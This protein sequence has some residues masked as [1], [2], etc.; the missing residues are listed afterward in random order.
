MIERSAF[1]WYPPML[2]PA[3]D[4]YQASL[5]SR[6][7]GDTVSYAYFQDEDPN[8]FANITDRVDSIKATGIH[9]MNLSGIGIATYLGL[10]TGM[11][12]ANLGAINTY[13]GN[14][15]KTAICLTIAAAALYGVA[16]L[17]RKA[18]EEYAKKSSIKAR[19]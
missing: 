12:F 4:S 17:P 15:E 9:T 10:I 19:S 6:V 11:R 18:R 1:N 5:I 14:I 16:A 7:E 2:Q 8:T 3:V 13:H